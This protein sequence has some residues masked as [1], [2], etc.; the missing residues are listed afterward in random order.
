MVLRV[1]KGAPMIGFTL[2]GVSL[3]PSITGAVAV[4]SA[5]GEPIAWTLQSRVTHRTARVSLT[6]LAVKVGDRPYCLDV[7]P[8]RRRT[9]GWRHTALNAAIAALLADHP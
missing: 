4:R 9:F 2:G 5:N 7:P 6:S 3:P 1:L 8:Q